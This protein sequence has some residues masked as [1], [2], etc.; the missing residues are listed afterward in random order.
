M[1]HKQ[2]ESKEEDSIILGEGNETSPT[3]QKNLTLDPLGGL[4]CQFS[5]NFAARK[6]VLQKS[7]SQWKWE[8][9]QSAPLDVTT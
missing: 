1:L 5:G 4:F 6:I 7:P 8:G 9:K 3:E 2:E